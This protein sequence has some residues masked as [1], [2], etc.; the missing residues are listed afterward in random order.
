MFIE[1]NHNEKWKSSKEV[2]DLNNFENEEELN[3][4]TKE[5]KWEEYQPID[6]FN[7]FATGKLYY[8]PSHYQKFKLILEKEC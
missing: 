3:K 6:F 7:N 8:Y 5:A 2:Y 1:N 4:V